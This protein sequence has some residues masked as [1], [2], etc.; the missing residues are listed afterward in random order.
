MS[1]KYHYN[2]FPPNNIRHQDLQAI[3]AGARTELGRYDGL[4][5]A[6]S[7]AELLLT[8]LFQQEAVLSS[9][10]EGTQSSLSEVLE[11]EADRNT[12]KFSAEEKHD[13]QEIINYRLAIEKATGL[14]SKYPLSQRILLKSHKILMKGVRG[15]NSAAGTYRSIPNWI[16]SGGQNMDD[17]R[18][19]PIDADKI[20]HAMS[21][22]E[23]YIHEEDSSDDLLK[24]AVL[25]AEFESIHPFLDGNGRLGRIFIPLF[26]WN[27][28]LIQS[29]SF[30]MSAYFESHRQTYYDRLLNVSKDDQWTEWCHFFLQGIVE[31]S[32]NNYDR[33]KRILELYN[34]LKGKIPSITKSQYGI[35]ALDFIFNRPYFTSTQFYSAANI[36]KPTAQRLL[37][38]LWREKI[39]LRFKRSGRS[40]DAHVFKDLM[41]ITEG[42]NVF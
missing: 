12:K 39:L 15:K 6:I 21:Q 34:R 27:K 20:P 22:W 11:F 13:I 41:N 4:L 14:L 17:A 31:E 18:F 24:A 10:I 32:K 29:P 26:L 33:A 1:V 7:N 35:V 5:T 8:P 30:Y 36:P 3:I 23:K 28:K 9:R 37:A 42:K 2:K 16:G 38:V 40:P 25:H 19:I